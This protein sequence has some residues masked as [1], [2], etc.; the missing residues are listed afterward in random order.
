MTR[1]LGPLRCPSDPQG[2]VCAHACICAQSHTMHTCVY[3]T[4]WLCLRG[5]AFPQ[6]CLNAQTSGTGG[7]E[8]QALHDPTLPRLR[9]GLLRGPN[10]VVFN[11]KYLAV[12]I[13]T[14]AL[15]WQ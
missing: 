8:G 4:P 3:G 14:Q 2:A 7:G 1:E 13:E 12:A 10:M 5:G 9:P 6:M 11:S 15:A